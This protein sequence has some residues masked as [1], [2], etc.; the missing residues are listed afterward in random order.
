[1]GLSQ[2]DQKKAQNLRRQPNDIAIKETTRTHTLSSESTVEWSCCQMDIEKPYL[3]AKLSTKAVPKRSAMS[4]FKKYKL[5]K[6]KAPSEK[7][8][9]ADF[10]NFFGELGL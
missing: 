8:H 6:R 2:D 4:E 1:M 10:F 9:D 7:L 3:W 5:C